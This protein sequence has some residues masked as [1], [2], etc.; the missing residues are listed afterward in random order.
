LNIKVSLLHHLRWY[1]H[2]PSVIKIILRVIE[3]KSFIWIV[4][5]HVHQGL[6]KYLYILVFQISLQ[7]MLH[8]YIHL[9]I[10]LFIQP[11]HL[12]IQQ[13]NLFIYL[14][15]HLSIQPLYLFIQSLHLHIHLFIQLLH[16]YIHLYIHLSIQL[17]VR[18]ESS[19]SGYPMSHPQKRRIT[20]WSDYPSDWS[21]GSLDIWWIRWNRLSDIWSK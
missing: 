12:Y 17:E 20:D 2:V 13:L 4:E 14:Y 15:I 6:L 11:F 8:L 1:H 16:L 3:I 18:S 19:Q 10:H 21:N 5:F 7:V 9:F